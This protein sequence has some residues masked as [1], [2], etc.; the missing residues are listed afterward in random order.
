MIQKLSPVYVLAHSGFAIRSC[1]IADSQLILDLLLLHVP[2]GCS[3]AVF[4]FLL[5]ARGDMLFYSV[6]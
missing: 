3:L 4:L 2:G 1:P 6:C 5:D